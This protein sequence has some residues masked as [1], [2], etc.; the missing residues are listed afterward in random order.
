MLERDILILP[1]L[2]EGKLD[3]LTFE[4]SAKGRELA[5][6][7]KVKL[8]ALLLGHKLGPLIQTIRG[9][10]ANVIL[11]ADHPDLE[12]YNA[13]IYL[14]LISKVL[15]DLRPSF[16]LLGYT[17][18][19]IELGPAL[20]ARFNS[21]MVSNCI[22]LQ[23]D[24]GTVR[25]IRP[26]FSGTYHTNIELHG[27]PPYIISFQKGVLPTL[28]GSLGPA[29]VVEVPV[30]LEEVSLRSKAIQILQPVVGE[31]DITK[32]EVVVAVGRGIANKAN[33]SMIKDLA[34]ALGGTI[35]CSRPISD[36]G[37]LPEEYHVGL[38]GKTVAPKVYIA[39]GISGASQHV[40]GMK[41]SGR[42]MAINKDPNAPIFDVAHYGIVGDLF[43]VIPELTSQARKVW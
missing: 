38:S 9:A 1:E 33:I 35:A 27:S 24:D 36:L 25:V 31:I 42:I 14:N 37:W 2:K 39:C 8:F 18:W 30:E 29:E 34:Q 7:L 20:A 11:V 17:Y 3:S 4:L 41:D 21:L 16:F 28:E 40:V 43:K 22:D 32:A 6:K 26:M 12:N 13:E 5:D 19:G 10:G 23:L 15:S